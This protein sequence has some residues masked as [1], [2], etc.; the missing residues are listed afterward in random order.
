MACLAAL[1]CR[2]AGRVL[3]QSPDWRGLPP[4]ETRFGLHQ[5]KALVGHFGAPDRMNYTAMGDAVNV[6]SRLEGL[7][8]QYGTSIIASDRIFEDARVHFDFRLLDWVAVKGKT[9]AIKIYELLDEKNRAGELRRPSRRMKSRS[10]CGAEFRKSDRHFGAKQQRPAQCDFAQSL[11]RI[12]KSAAARGLARRPCLDVE[13][14]SAKFVM[15]DVKKR[16]LI[17]GGGFESNERWRRGGRGQGD[18]ETERVAR[19]WPRESWRCAEDPE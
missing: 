9:G 10:L 1:R 4:F 3:S 2:E 5:E 18:G 13:V 7:N 14:T 15:T 8:K 17:L 19:M 16:V 12:S 11:P 6:A